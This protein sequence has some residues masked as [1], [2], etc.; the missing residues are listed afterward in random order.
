MTKNKI[1]LDNISIQMRNQILEDMAN[2][3]SITTE[4]AYNELTDE[5]TEN[6]YEY[7]RDMQL[8]RFV[9]LA[10]NQMKRSK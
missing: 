8:K 2:N 1:F 3:Y 7:I 9:Y 10:F 5:D 6:V 4:Q